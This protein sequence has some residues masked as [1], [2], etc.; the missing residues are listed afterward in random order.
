MNIFLAIFL[1]CIYIYPIFHFLGYVETKLEKLRNK[2]NKH[3]LSMG[4][5]DTI[6]YFIGI[7]LLFGIPSL[8]MLG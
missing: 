8:L 7:T 1:W 4:L 6:V 5:V 3:K 2:D